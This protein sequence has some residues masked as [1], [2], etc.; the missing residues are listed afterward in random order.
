MRDNVTDMGTV[1]DLLATLG[2]CNASRQNLYLNTKLIKTMITVVACD[3][4]AI[5]NKRNS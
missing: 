3:I 1:T 5:A 4:F 2:K